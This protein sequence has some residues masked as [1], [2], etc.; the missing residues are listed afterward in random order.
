MAVAY[1]AVAYLARSKFP[2][3]LSGIVQLGAGTL[4]RDAT[5]L[6]AA[7]SARLLCVAFVKFVTK[8]N[9]QS[10]SGAALRGSSGNSGLTLP[11]INSGALVFLDFAQT[12]PLSGS[13]RQWAAMETFV[14]RLA[15]VSRI[16]SVP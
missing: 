10:S 2:L 8:I 14:L 6:H 11:Q 13:Q 4:Q 7:S 1:L 9:K 16:V 3:G 15:A 12:V 5:T